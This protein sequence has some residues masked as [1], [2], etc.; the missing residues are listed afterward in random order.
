LGRANGLSG[1]AQNLALLVG[2]GLGGV[3][4]AAVDP[5]LCLG[6]DAATFAVS[7]GTLMLI[8]PLATAA[9]DEVEPAV[10]N[11]AALRFL[12]GSALMRMVI[13]LTLVSNLAYYGM[14]EVALPVL[15][16]DVLRTAAYGYGFALAA[17]GLGSL[18]GG[19]AIAALERRPGRGLIACLFGMAQGLFFAAIAIRA[20][21]GATVTLMALAGL[22]CGLLNVFYLSRVQEQVP[23]ALLGRAMSVLMLAV[24]A[25]HPVSVAVAAAIATSTGPQLVFAV[26][27]AS[28]V[29]A[30]AIGAA[31]K[32][33]RNL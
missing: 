9:T 19:L 7:V 27:G 4:A 6:L 25:I 21:L 22:T 26:A 23:S 10:G 12:A 16:A 8:R 13:A 14:L 20:D 3:L 2:P 15:S 11:R 29:V 31:T 1:G 18:L 33:Y 17:F 28:I 24:F 32:T 5:R 30:F